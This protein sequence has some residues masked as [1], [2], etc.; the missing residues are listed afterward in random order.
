MGL[1]AKL[2]KVIGQLRL[3]ERIQKGRRAFWK[4]LCECGKTTEI[5]EDSLRARTSLSCGHIKPRK[6][7]TKR[8]FG[9]L[10]PLERS[11]NHGRAYW[12][13]LCTCGNKTTVREDSLIEGNTKSCGCLQTDTPRQKARKQGK[14]FFY[15][16]K[17][18][19]GHDCLRYVADARCIECSRDKNKKWRKEHHVEKQPHPKSIAR[20]KKL[21]TY[22]TGVL[23]SY[24]HNSDR[25]TSNGACLKC[26]V[27]R[28]ADTRE[29]RRVANKVYRKTHKG[30]INANTAKRRAVLL[31]AC[32]TWARKG[33]VQDQMKRIYETCPLKYDVDH[34]VPL[35]NSLVCG[36]HVPWNLQH[37]PKRKNY[38]KNNNFDSYWTNGNEMRIIQ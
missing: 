16:G 24:G 26:T 31:Q 18:R 19:R 12:T 25:Y 5:R 2:P 7:F 11:E 21:K 3:L 6:G 36:L 29:Q 8:K 34:I 32:P 20:E 35:Q 4:C 30:I 37:L 23:C 27:I 1:F 13:C 17:C 38:S 33:S 22:Y 15:A 28:R 14:K 10:R 9:R